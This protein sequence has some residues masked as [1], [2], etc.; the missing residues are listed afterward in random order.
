MYEFPNISGHF[1]REV[2]L[3]AL[4]TEGTGTTAL[5]EE[6][7]E[8]IR[9]CIISCP[10]LEILT[11]PS[12]K[13]IFSHIEWEMEGYLVRLPEGGREDA[14][15]EAEITGKTEAEAKP[16]TEETWALREELLQKYSIP[17]AFRVYTGIALEILG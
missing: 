8:E 9:S 5:P 10:D 16:E 11:L 3:A 2:L 14:Y 17:S 6:A 13:H 12:A 7:A 1:K 15:W 4:R